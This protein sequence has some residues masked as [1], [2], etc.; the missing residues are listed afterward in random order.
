MK[1]TKNLHH[2]WL[3][4]DLMALGCLGPSST[5]FME[6][7]MCSFPFSSCS[8]YQPWIPLI[9][10]RVQLGLTHSTSSQ[11]M[12]AHPIK[13][14]AM[15]TKTFPTLAVLSTFMANFGSKLNISRSSKY[16]GPSH[17]LYMRWAIHVSIHA[18]GIY[19]RHHKALTISTSTSNVCW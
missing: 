11:P 4:K 6:T 2:G 18:I 12:I 3:R 5:C 16:H 14:K 15:A 13:K 7:S 19:G 10:S 17:L 9:S 1:N 8:L